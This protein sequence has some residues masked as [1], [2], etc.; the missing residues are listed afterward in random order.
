MASEA[1]EGDMKREKIIMI[2]TICPSDFIMVSPENL[3]LTHT[4]PQ[5]NMLAPKSNFF[6]SHMFGTMNRKLEFNFSGVR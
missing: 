5:Y 4:D 3:H 6:L 2:I 1:K